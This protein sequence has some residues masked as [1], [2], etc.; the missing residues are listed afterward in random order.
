MLNYSTIV[1]F[2]KY[3]RKNRD[4]KPDVEQK[5]IAKQMI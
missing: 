1:F 2:V 5:I 3:Q 4:E